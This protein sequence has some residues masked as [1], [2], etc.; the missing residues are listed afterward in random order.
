MGKLF[1][2]AGEPGTG[3]TICLLVGRLIDCARRPEDRA[4]TGSSRAR[5]SGSERKGCLIIRVYRLRLRLTNDEAGRA[6]FRV[7]HG[8]VVRAAMFSAVPSKPSTSYW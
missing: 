1:R 6:G 4:E 5:R 2:R 7:L 8:V 3:W